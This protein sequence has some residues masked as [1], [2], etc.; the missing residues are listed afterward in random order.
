MT[1]YTLSS[2]TL[3]TLALSMLESFPQAKTFPSTKAI[4]SPLFSKQEMENNFFFE[5]GT[6]RMLLRCMFPPYSS[7]NVVDPIPLTT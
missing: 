3:I 1:L 2:R 7:C 6:Y 5:L 4:L